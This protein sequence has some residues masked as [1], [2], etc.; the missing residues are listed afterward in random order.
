MS[1]ND[2]SH[3]LQRLEAWRAQEKE[4]KLARERA[5]EATN[6]FVKCTARFLLWSV[7]CQVA[8]LVAFRYAVKESTGGL[9]SFTCALF[10]AGSQ[11]G[12]FGAW[13]WQNF[14]SYSLGIEH[15][16][17]GTHSEIQLM[18]KERARRNARRTRR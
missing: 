5:I 16:R 17:C 8:S 1:S 9:G 18:L 14:Q 2:L 11:L 7:C 12:V 10:F 6:K 15:G 13:W 3:S 4:R